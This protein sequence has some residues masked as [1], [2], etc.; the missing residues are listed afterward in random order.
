MNHLSLVNI[1]D[2]HRTR[3]NRIPRNAYQATVSSRIKLLDKQTLTYSRI[4]LTGAEDHAPELGRVS[5][6]S[7]LGSE[8]L[9]SEYGQ[10]ISIDVLGKEIEFQVLSVVNTLPIKGGNH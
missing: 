7:S 1:F 5:Y 2:S 8:L 10:Y 3:K 6:L 4:T 9:G